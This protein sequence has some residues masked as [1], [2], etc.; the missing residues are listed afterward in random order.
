MVVCKS[1]HKTSQ[2]KQTQV[3]LLPKGASDA[4]STWQ[5]R[6]AGAGASN[7]WSVV[8]SIEH[9][10][11]PICLILPECAKVGNGPNPE[12]PDIKSRREPQILADSP[13]PVEIQAFGGHGKLQISTENRRCSQQ[14]AENCRL[15]SGTLGPFTLSAAPTQ[16][17]QTLKDSRFSSGIENFKRE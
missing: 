5:A 9:L 12:G 10:S 6:I 16:R 17:S 11:R 15:G 2:E 8:A 1:F 14:N 3:L 7:L 4:P 13:L